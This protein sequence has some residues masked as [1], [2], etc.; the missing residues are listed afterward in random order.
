[1]LDVVLNFQEEILMFINSTPALEGLK[2]DKYE[3]DLLWSYAIFFKVFYD[4]TID[5]SC[6]YYPTFHLL[7]THI[8]N[9]T[10]V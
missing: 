3:F 5:L 7:W 2:F 10:C 4:A 8:Y 9:N 6:T 1:M